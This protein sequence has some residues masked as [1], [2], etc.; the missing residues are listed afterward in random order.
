MTYKGSILFRRCENNP[1]MHEQLPGGA[2]ASDPAPDQRPW[3]RGRAERDGL[4]AG[5]LHLTARLSSQPTY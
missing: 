2:S 3:Q 5:P 1:K 4:A